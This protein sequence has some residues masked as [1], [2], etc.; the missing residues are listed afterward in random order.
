[1]TEKDRNATD[2]SIFGH[3]FT[4]KG[5]SDPAY[6]L[7]LAAKVDEKMKELAK[8]KPGEPIHRVALLTA[9]VLMDELT[10]A[11]R[12]LDEERVRFDQASR[13]IETLEQRLRAL[14]GEYSTADPIAPSELVEQAETQDLGVWD[15]A[16]DLFD[17]PGRS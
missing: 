2:I 11:R 6:M 12:A 15:Q 5:P 4:L 3:K 10:R 8:P 7:E 9:L 1:M 13:S 17:E 16:R 14:L